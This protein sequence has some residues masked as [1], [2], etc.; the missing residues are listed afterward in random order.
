[1]LLGSDSWGDWGYWGVMLPV[2]IGLGF[3]VGVVAY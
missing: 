2:A 3:G 1:M